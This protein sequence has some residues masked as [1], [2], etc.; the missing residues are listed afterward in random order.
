MTRALHTAGRSSEFSPFSPLLRE[1]IQ[2]VAIVLSRSAHLSMWPLAI[3]LTEP[4]ASPCSCVDAILCSYPCELHLLRVLLH[5]STSYAC[6][7]PRSPTAHY[8]FLFQLARP[9][10]VFSSTFDLHSIWPRRYPLSRRTSSFHPPPQLASPAP[11]PPPKSSLPQL[12]QL[13]SSASLLIPSVHPQLTHTKSP[14]PAPPPMQPTFIPLLP[15][16]P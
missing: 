9:L 1:P 5:A 13:A 15:R 8:A 11:R 4:L 6:L 3:D 2:P 7:P 14:S 12:R 10:H 16:K